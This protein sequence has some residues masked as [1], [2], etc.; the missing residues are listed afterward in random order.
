MSVGEGNSG[1]GGGDGIQGKG[2][3]ALMYWK[4]HQ[5]SIENIDKKN[6]QKALYKANKKQANAFK[7]QLL[8][9][10]QSSKKKEENILVSYCLLNNTLSYV[11]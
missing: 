9:P 7:K 8:K 1:I 2:P 10:K 5:K 4:I 6:R 11:S 3:V